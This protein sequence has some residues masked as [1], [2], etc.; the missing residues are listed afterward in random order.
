MPEG[1]GGAPLKAVV[2]E[3]YLWLQDG[4]GRVWRGVMNK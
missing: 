2:S 3:G 1:F 4:K